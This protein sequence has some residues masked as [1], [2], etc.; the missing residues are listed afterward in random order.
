MIRRP[1]R[2]PAIYGGFAKMPEWKRRSAAAAAAAMRAAGKD[3]AFDAEIWKGLKEYLL[4]YFHGKCAYCEVNI[5]AGF[6]GDVEH[7]RPKKK[8]EEAPKHRGYYWLAYTPHNLMP[9]CQLC[10]Q[11]K[12][13]K[14][15]FPLANEKLRAR[16]PKDLAAERPLLLNPYTD[17]PSLHLSFEFDLSGQPTG[18]LQGKT[19]KGT[20]SVRIYNLNREDLVLARKRAQQDTVFAIVGSLG[21]GSFQSFFE[22]IHDGQRDYSAARKAAVEYFLEKNRLRVI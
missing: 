20:T 3:H 22:A 2:E 19:P 1:Y 11:G 9:S 14:N 6:W 21:A 17:D 5:T 13:K 12:G 16:R 15:H 18:Y 8:V 10:N 7:Y 4:A